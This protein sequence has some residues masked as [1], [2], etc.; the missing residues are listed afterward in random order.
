[1]RK[2]WAFCKINIQN[3]VTYRGPILVWL[4]CNTLSLM[5]IVAVWLSASGREIIGGYS[6]PEL[7]SYYIAALFLE[8]IVGW[9]P[10][11]WLSD[12]IKN[13]EITIHTLIKPI[14]IFKKAFAL[15]V[16]WHLVSSWIGLAASLFLVFFF[17][18]TIAFNFYFSRLF[19]L[20]LV[21]PL[22]IL[23]T[24]S[25]SLCMG[26]LAFWFTEIMA[27]DSVYW[28][29]R[30]ILG[31]Q[32]IPISF[33]P[34]TYQFLVKLLPFRYMFSFPLEIYFGKLTETEII[35]GL[36]IQIF[37]FLI[38]VRVYKLMWR[39]GRRAYTAFGH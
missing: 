35:Q 26:L 13:G 18:Q 21:V 38:L 1:M 36:I 2:Y 14:S 22:S 6:K 31:G 4:I 34:Q 19:L 25:L 32:G 29:G 16:G 5:T 30:T 12:E 33:I 39:T 9:F 23:I 10:F 3:T 20:V 28:A 37:W 7:V 8:W 17:R 27:I 15:E 24:F 11:Y